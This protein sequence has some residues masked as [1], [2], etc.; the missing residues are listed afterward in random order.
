MGT[1]RL[2]R[3]GKGTAQ[4]RVN[5]AAPRGVAM[6]RFESNNLCEAVQARKAVWELEI[7]ELGVGS[8]KFLSTPNFQFPTPHPAHFAG[9]GFF[10][11]SAI[12]EFQFFS[13]FATHA[14]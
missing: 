9:G 5:G 6:N 14:L 7:W 3:C 2:W 4:P 1:R 13:M 12:S 11:C 8:W 10:V